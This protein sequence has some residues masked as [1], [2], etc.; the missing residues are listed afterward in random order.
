MVYD[1][2]RASLWKRIAAGL[3]D[4]ILAAV[5]AVGFAFLLSFVLGFDQHSQTVSEAYSTY[6]TAYGVDFS[7]SAEAYG[8]LTDAERGQ[9]DDAYAA[10]LADEAAM[11]AYNMTVNLSMVI[12][13]AAVFF[14]V[15]AFEYV[16]PLIFGNGQTLGK[17]IFALGLMR[18]DGVRMNRMQ[19]LI[20]ALLGRFTIETMLPIYLILLMFWGSIGIVGTFLLLGLLLVQ[21]ILLAVTRT[22]AQ[23]HDLLAGTV[24]VDLPSQMIFDTEAD[25]I[26]YKKKQHAEAVAEA[27]D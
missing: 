3:F 26:E 23:I 21:L 24:V 18:T 16:I 17:K 10:L 15:M 11:Y 7:I 9:Y 4:G 20:R 22:R 5:L 14:A 8:A 1:L 13:T 12:S 19:L 27:R 25:L 6:E 2:Q